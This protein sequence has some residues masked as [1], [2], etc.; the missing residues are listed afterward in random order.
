[1][2][3]RDALRSALAE[4]R[5][6][7]KRTILYA[8][9][10]LIDMDTEFYRVHGKDVAVQ[11]EDGTPFRQDWQKYRSFPA[12]KCVLACQS[13]PKWLE[14]MRSLALQA[15]E[16]GADGIL[17]D[18]LGMTGPIP[19]WATNH[20]HAAP[21]MAY[22]DDRI[23]WLRR[24]ADEMKRI[25]P[26]FIVMTE[27]LHDSV[28]DSIELFH[29]CV[30]GE[31]VPTGKDDVFPE[32]FRYTFPEVLNTQRHSTPMLNRL[33]ANY[34]CV[35]GLR[36]EIE[37]RYAPD[38][39]YLKEGVVP[40]RADYADVL[41]PPNVTMMNATPSAEAT[42]YLKQVID[43]ERRYASLLWRGRFV[44]DEGFQ[45]K[46]EHLIAKAYAAG[47][48]LGILVW[49][50]GDQP[51]TFSLN[52]PQAKLVTAT[53]PEYEKVEPFSPLPAQSI[54]LLVWE[55][56]APVIL[57]PKPGP[58][59]RIN[60][61]KV[62]GVR[63]GHPILYTIA[64]T[65]QRP[66]KFSATGLPSGAR[67]D[68][69]TGRISGSIT[70]RGTYRVMLRAEN[71]LGRAE[72]E[73]RLVVGDD[74]CLTPLLGCNTWGGWGAKV[75]DANL[76]AA[77][78]AMV[79]LDLINHGWQYINIDDGWQ[80][81]RGGKLN[82]IQPNEKFPNMRSLSDYIHSL[83]LKAGIYST[84]WTTSYAGFVGGSSDDPNGAWEKPKRAR[85][86]YRF[87]KHFF[88]ANDARQW[89]EWGFDYAKYDWGIDSVEVT[90]RMADALAGCKRDIVLELSN[91][92]PLKLAPECVRLAQLSRTTGDLVDFW[93]RS[94]MDAGLGKWAVGIREVM[95][96]HDAYAPF[97]RPGHWNHACNLR[98]GLLGG[99]RDKPLTPTH[100]T[101]NEQYSHISL[102]CLWSSPMIIGTPIERLD[103][104]TLSLLSNDEVLEINQDPLG[105]QAVRTVI[106][107]GGEILVKDLEDGTKAVG[108]FNPGTEAASLTVSWSQVGV[109][110]P[111]RVRDLWRQKDLGVFAGRFETK[112]PSHGV[113]LV[114]VM[115]APT[116]AGGVTYYIDSV[117]GRNSNTGTL[118]E[119]PW[120]DFSNINGQ[121]L[122]PGDRLLIKR[123]SVINQELQLSAKG[124]AEHWAEIGAYG[125][126]A[127]PIIHRNWFIADRCAL[128]KSPEHLRIRSLTVSHAGKG[129]IVTTPRNLLI[130]DCIAHHIEG[131]YRPNS[132]G[133]PEWRDVPEQ[134][135]D[136]MIK[137][138]GIAVTGNGQDI[139]LRDCEM[140]Q[141]SWG[142]FVSGERVTV[143]RVYCH[144]NY[145]F[146]TSPHPALVSVKDA[147]MQNSVFDAS[148]YH[149]HAGTMGIML[150]NPRQLTIRNCTFRNQ[151]DSGC[152]D[153][154]GLDFEARGDG[155][156]IENCTFQNNAGAAIEVLG[157][158]LP[159]PKNVE[160][161]NSRFIQNNWAKKL[162][163]S[164]IFIWG[165]KDP[166]VCC[167][168]GTI[169]DNGCVLLPSV[170][171]FTNQAPA[172]TQ[173]ALRNNTTYPTVQAL[174]KAMPFNKPPV[175]KAGPDIITDRLT[176]HLNGSVTDDGRWVTKRWELLEGPGTV[177]FRDQTA[178]FSSP[179]DYLLRL[180]GDDGELWTSDTV[181]VHVLPRG[182]SVV[183]AWEFNT[184]L[185]KQGWTEADLGTKV[186]EEK[187]P[188]WP[189]KSYPVNYVAGG[190]YIVSV[191]DAPTARLLSADNLTV[192]IT[193]HKFV[194]LRLQN[195]TAAKRMTLHFTTAANNMWQSQSF[196]VVPNDDAVRDYTVNMS[197][198]PGWT[199]KLRQLRFDL[200]GGAPATGTCRFDYIWIANKP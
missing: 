175:V 84:P 50:K 181:T 159:Q 49:N 119:W 99:W 20:G 43:F 145:A 19:C 192:P 190:Y 80:G 52:V 18:Q 33:G 35:Y 34:A 143:D 10:Q 109:S 90:R 197:S 41:N 151:P 157:L 62:F 172:T 61:A 31:F 13:A 46:G 28:L 85:D 100:L 194:R 57:T 155:C 147:V 104:F 83:G 121:T 30:F 131:H 65:G 149:A 168:T 169:S 152:H 111:Q 184:P 48:Q 150:V 196:D 191:E 114:K 116:A 135:D 127:R 92:M 170:T 118:P 72:W 200:T 182:S 53:E 45:F 8:N 81:K 176:V 125:E 120:Q 38:V 106:A 123:G 108:I 29:G 173:W 69:K 198:V 117:G 96:Q 39:R 124:T 58:Q 162:G 179:G 42:R 112:V 129:L 56:Q 128:I 64:A 21:T 9:G 137:S 27:G 2:G 25:A 142:F 130:E 138:A 177:T 75:T 17:F 133:I 44:D 12:V 94:R 140:F 68:G 126:G 167:S 166:K 23:A 87:G 195:H 71:G 47:N 144:H 97:Q 164:E 174:E 122:G 183:K 74:I 132:S 160:I 1:M 193:R 40:A 32:M 178:T 110:G 89:A 51:T 98:V 139:T 185:D 7:G 199:G 37:S 141:T 161:R 63:P 171:F 22:T 105:K 113:T 165:S 66:M 189:C 156:L 82:A 186:R 103:E 180:V 59:P 77:A 55:K 134:K 60:G 26:G 36:H 91:S 4:A 86:G 76:R 101:P 88:E 102:W 3:G 14:R 158:S 163:P 153:E 6:R 93:D 24:I 5:R 115:P 187:H 154:G 11:Q 95:L 78:E 146:N 70:K 107:N 148:G 16:L 188:Q 15:H 136:G 54:R 67:L 73:L 79:R